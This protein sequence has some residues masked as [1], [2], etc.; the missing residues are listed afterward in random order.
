M[1]A[2]PEGSDDAT[3]IVS[4]PVPVSGVAAV[5]SVTVT[6]N[7]VVPLADG[8]PVMVPP[9]ESASPAGGEPSQV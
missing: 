3:M 1:T 9:G 2:S 6:V 7:S 5:E 8:V 4:W